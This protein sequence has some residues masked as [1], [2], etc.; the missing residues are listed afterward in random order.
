[1]GLAAMILS[2]LD[3]MRGRWAAYCLKAEGVTV[4]A[5]PYVKGRVQVSYGRNIRIGDRARLGG[6][7]ILSCA[8]QGSIK[9]CH[10]VLIN[11]YT[12]INSASS[13]IIEDWVTIAPFCQIIDADHGIEDL[14]RPVREQRENDV[15]APVHLKRDVWLG[16]HVVVLKGVTIGAGAVIGAGSIVTRDIPDGAIAVGVPAK[17]VGQRGTKSR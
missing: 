15:L 16:T 2:R 17:V 3:R 1:M 14:D 12:V 9:I 11:D 4:G 6:G 7:L 10:D 5:E 13:V 8:S